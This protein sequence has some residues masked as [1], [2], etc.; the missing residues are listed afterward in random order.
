MFVGDA[1]VV[2]AVQ[3]ERNK[4]RLLVPLLGH[5]DHLHMRSAYPILISPT[6]PSP[7]IYPRPHTLPSFTP[8]LA[9]SHICYM[10]L[11][12]PY[13]HP[14]YRF[15]VTSESP[16]FTLLLFALGVQLSL[17]ELYLEI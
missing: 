17:C 1:V 10:D 11:V 2:H 16:P 6:H 14:L 5:K 12:L 7:S 8:L 13:G 4:R 3:M 9:Y 15:L